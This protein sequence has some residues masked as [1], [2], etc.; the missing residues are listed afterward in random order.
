MSK[1]NGLIIAAGVVGGVLGLSWI[2]MKLIELN[3]TRR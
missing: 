3:Y 1:G 2:V